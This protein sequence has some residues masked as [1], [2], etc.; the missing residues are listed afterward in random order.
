[1]APIDDFVTYQG[2]NYAIGSICILRPDY[3]VGNALLVRG[4]TVER[5]QQRDGSDLWAVR[6]GPNCLDKDGDWVYEPLP[7]SRDDEWLAMHRWAML[8]DAMS[9]AITALAKALAGKEANNA[10][11]HRS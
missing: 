5:C 11:A 8:T 2:S 1:M 6:S 4:V 9:A 3:K 7:S 10:Q